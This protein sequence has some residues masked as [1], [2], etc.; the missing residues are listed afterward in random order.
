MRIC[1]GRTAHNPTPSGWVPVW[2]VSPKVTL[3]QAQDDVSMSQE[4][5]NLANNK[6]SRLSGVAVFLTITVC[7]GVQCVTM[8]L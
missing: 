4:R 1:H 6:P 7:G 3:R 2:S 5:H 8:M